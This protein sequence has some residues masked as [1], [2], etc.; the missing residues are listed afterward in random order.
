MRSQSAGIVAL[1][2][3]ALAFAT[4]EAVMTL[5]IGC[6]KRVS[7]ARRARWSISMRG[8][9]AQFVHKRLPPFLAGIGAMAT[10]DESA[11][12]A[13]SD[14]HRTLVAAEAELGQHHVAHLEGLDGDAAGQH[15]RAV[16]VFCGKRRDTRGVS[17]G[18]GS[19]A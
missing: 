5:H 13:W 14:A 19:G 8:D 12:P 9:E 2:S 3:S 11:S 1:R 6:V 4:T 7:R 15:P 16:G 17:T 10:R 18:K